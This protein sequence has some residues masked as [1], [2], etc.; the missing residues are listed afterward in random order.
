[1]QN[2]QHLDVGSDTL[3]HGFDDLAPRVEFVIRPG[4]VAVREKEE[5][6]QA[7]RWLKQRAQEELFNQAEQRGAQLFEEHQSMMRAEAEKTTD[8]KVL[9]DLDGTVL[10]WAVAMYP[11]EFE[12]DVNPKG[13]RKGFLSA[14]KGLK[15][16]LLKERF[17][18]RPEGGK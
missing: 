12:T 18:R 7:K 3:L 17:A 14:A 13:F 11:R 4:P 1:M 2:L 8:K 10:T 6:R 16:Q 5:R 9:S 15:S